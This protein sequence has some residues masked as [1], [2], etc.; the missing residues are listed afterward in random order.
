MTCFDIVDSYFI[1]PGGTFCLCC[2]SLKGLHLYKKFGINGGDG[3]NDDDYDRDD[4]SSL[5]YS[6]MWQLLV[7]LT[8]TEVCSAPA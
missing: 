7:A 8:I 2:Q 5:L 4:D 6:E 1:L 3:S